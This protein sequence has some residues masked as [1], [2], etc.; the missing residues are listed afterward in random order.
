MAT[1]AST[2]NIAAIKEC[3]KQAGPGERTPRRALATYLEMENRAE[4]ARVAEGMTVGA[5][6]GAGLRACIDT[7]AGRTDEALAELD[8]L[9]ALSLASYVPPSLLAPVAGPLGHA[10]QAIASLEEGFVALDTSYPPCAASP[11]R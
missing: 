11:L 1:I 8:R 4:A 6:A 2:D 5:P 7:V 3:A 10:D 9:W